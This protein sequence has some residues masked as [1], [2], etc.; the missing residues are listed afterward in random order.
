MQQDLGAPIAEDKLTAVYEASIA[1]CD[2]ELT[3]Q[4][5]GYINDLANCRYDPTKDVALLCKA[6]GGRN[7]TSHCLT[8]AE[9]RAVNKIWYGPRVDGNMIDPAIDNGWNLTGLARGQLW[10]GFP[11][12][13]LLHNSLHS[14]GIGPAGSTPFSLY[15]DWLALTLLNPAYA[16]PMFTNETGNG[17]DLW[18]TIRYTGTLSFPSVLAKSQAT[19]IDLNTSNPDLTEFKKAGGKLIHWHGL[20]DNI[21][22]ALGSV[23]YYERVSNRM[24]G[25]AA[26]QAFYRFFLV[27]GIGHGVTSGPG[28]TAPVPGGDFKSYL[29]P[30]NAMIQILRDWVENGKAPDSIAAESDTSATPT[31]SRRWCMYPKK[32][33]YRGGDLRLAPSYTCA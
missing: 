21:I 23:Q 2:T 27:P 12:G 31:R 9:A 28:T 25:H 17:Q 16:T 33:K 29:G 6:A 26:T 19:F 15:G 13:V 8:L 7:S 3:G 11:R 30:N 14:F 20:S 22:P 4:H 18:K 32:L 1:A 10:Y 24:G 5:D